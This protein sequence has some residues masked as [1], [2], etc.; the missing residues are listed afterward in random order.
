MST[1]KTLI[2]LL[3]EK[4]E[5]YGKTNYELIKFKLLKSTALIV[6][7]LI[8]RLIIVLVI[9]CFTL[10]LSIGIALFFGDLLGKLYYGF[11]IIAAFY[12]VIGIILHF[13][14][15]NWIKKPVADSIIKQ[16]LKQQ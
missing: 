12:L 16:I 11:F 7:S 3:F 4:I 13:F 14:L 9:F 15:F 6:P 1:S 8:S 10:I 5:E 2:E